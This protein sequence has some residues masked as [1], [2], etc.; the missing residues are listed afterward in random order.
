VAPARKQDPGERFPW[1]KLAEAGI[2]LWP[3]GARRPHR[4]ALQ[5]G[6][7][8]SD[9]RILQKKLAQYGYGIEETGVYDTATG[10]VVTAF[11]RHFRPEAVTGAADG[12]TQGRLERLLVLAKA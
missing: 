7:T 10:L 2:G 6:M 9:V 1:A 8:G 11:Q 3:R 5:Q 4:R 12:E